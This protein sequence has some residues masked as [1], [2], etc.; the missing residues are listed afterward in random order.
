[1]KKE[2]MDAPIYNVGFSVLGPQHEIGYS[3]DDIILISDLKQFE[4]TLTVKIQMNVIVCCIDG[5]LQLDVDNETYLLTS[6]SVLVCHSKATI[7]NVMSSS[8][9]VCKVLLITD[10]ALQNLLQT[11]IVMWNK[12]LYIE[13]IKMLKFSDSHLQRALLYEQLI[14]SRVDVESK[15]NQS[16]VRSILH[17]ALLEFCE[18]MLPEK[19]DTQVNELRSQELFHRFI[20]LLSKNAGKKRSV[21]YYAEKLYISPKY[22]STICKMMSDKSPLQWIVEYEMEEIRSYLKNTDLSCKEISELMGFPNSSFFGRYV[23]DHTGMTP[24]EYR[25]TMRK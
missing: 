20:D 1:M 7:A 23:K 19:L 12:A 3:D 14:R 6:N 17:A 10:K 5:R 2:T 11:D 9:Y 21:T 16:V 18:M 15:L 13:K 25:L 22:F 24:L 8:S 4:Q